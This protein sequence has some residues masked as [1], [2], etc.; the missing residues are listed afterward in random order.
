METLHQPLMQL[1][2]SEKMA[3][4]GGLVAGMTHEMSSPL[5]IAVM[6]VSHL[7]A[8]TQK[9]QHEFLTSQLSRTSL[10]KFLKNTSESI[11]IIQKNLD[12]TADLLKSFKQMAIDRASE[13]KHEFNLLQYIDDILLSLKPKLKPTAHTVVV[14]CPKDLRIHSYPGIFSQIFTNLIMNS[15]THGF[16][17]I[18]NGQIR[19]NIVQDNDTLRVI[20]QDNGK[21]IPE[22]HLE[23]LFHLFFTTRYGQG[24]SGLGLNIIYNLVTQ[25]LGGKIMCESTV[26][27][28]TTFTI[29]IPSAMVQLPD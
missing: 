13:R 8:I 5:G 29:H 11:A 21:G 7:E 16:E 17:T 12:R 15:L 18:P 27:Q 23:K 24:G 6:A 20:Y 4:L 28:G 3:V 1:A 14:D 22:E 19:I 9:I 10:E 2:Q 26:G 25:K